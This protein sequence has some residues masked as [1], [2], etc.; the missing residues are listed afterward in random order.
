MESLEGMLLSDIV[1]KHP[2]ESRVLLSLAA[3]IAD[4]LEAVHA[5]GIVHRDIKASNIF[6]T[7]R[8]HIKVLDFGLAKRS[9]RRI[10]RTRRRRLRKAP[11][12]IR[13]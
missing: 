12:P 1:V 7:E 2:P 9:T 6:V 3:E 4:A 13:T 5:V 11:S 10:C 8:G